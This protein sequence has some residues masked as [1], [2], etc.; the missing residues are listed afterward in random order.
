M[1]TSP[2]QTVAQPMQS[3]DFEE[4][5]EHLQTAADKAE[6]LLQQL[7]EA[8]ATDLRESGDLP[9][10]SAEGGTSAGDAAS[11]QDAAAGEASL[12]AGQRR[13]LDVERVQQQNGTAGSNGIAGTSGANGRR[14][15]VDLAAR[16]RCLKVLDACCS[17]N[18]QPSL[19]S[20]ALQAVRGALQRSQAGG[21]ASSA[22][23]G[24]P[25]ASWAWDCAARALPAAAADV[26]ALMRGGDAGLGAGEVQVVAETL[27]LSVAALPAAGDRAGA[28]MSTLR[29]L[30]V[31]AAVKASAAPAPRSAAV[32]NGSRVPISAP[33]A[34]TLQNFALRS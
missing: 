6:V 11:G 22:Q 10:E 7:E 15:S 8:A 30:L 20:A 28:L 9:G 5:A 25:Q 2:Q 16:E 3:D 24:T 4:A 19:Q 27:K 13:S 12:M 31:E 1:A 21:V 32:A 17:C 14:A 34:I 26:H 33:P 23:M 18:A 29:I